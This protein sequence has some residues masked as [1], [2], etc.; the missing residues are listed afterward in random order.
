[1]VPLRRH[2]LFLV[3]SFDSSLTIRHLRSIPADRLR[4]LIAEQNDNMSNRIVPGRDQPSSWWLTQPRDRSK[5]VVGMR[6]VKPL[7]ELRISMVREGCTNRPFYTIQVKSNQAHGKDQGIE[8]VGSWDPFPNREHGE[9]LVGLNV[10]RILYWMSQGAQPTE[11]VAELLGLAGILP[12]HPHSL[13][14]AHR[15]R[16]AMSQM[17][18]A[19]ESKALEETQ[20]DADGADG[21]TNKSQEEEEDGEKVDDPLKRPDAIWRKKNSGEHWWRHGLM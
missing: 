18:K 11:R 21:D 15:A 3:Q 10:E 7:P 13:L 19:A 1:M 6:P 20:S 4:K 14:V 9:Q 16:C 8:Q 2:G 5:K 12:I 17:A